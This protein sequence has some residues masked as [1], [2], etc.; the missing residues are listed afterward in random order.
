[1]PYKS[2]Q[3]VLDITQEQFTFAEPFITQLNIDRSDAI[4]Y[5]LGRRPKPI[6]CRSKHATLDVLDVV[7]EIRALF[8]EMLTS[9][10]D[11]VEFTPRRATQRVSGIAAQQYVND[12]FLCRNPGVA[13]FGD[14]VFDAAMYKL[15]VFNLEW[16]KRDNEAV[17]TFEELSEDDASTLVDSPDIVL[18][19]IDSKDTPE[20]KQYF[21]KYR[22]TSESPRVKLR[23]V[24]PDHFYMHE[25]AT[26]VFNPDF[27]TEKV[28]A[29]EGDLR[30]MGIPQAKIDQ[31]PYYFLND[32]DTISNLNT[33][34][35][36]YANIGTNQSGR[37]TRR[38]YNSFIVN[39]FE[40][41]NEMRLYQV[42][43]DENCLIDYKQ[44]HR[45]YYFWWTPL[46]VSHKTI[47]L[48]Y[49]DTTKGVQAHSTNLRRAILDHA[50]STTNRT[51]YANEALF[52]D[53]QRL[54]NERF[55]EVHNV[56]DIGQAIR[57][58]EVPQISPLTANVIDMLEGEKEKRS[59]FSATARGQNQD[60]I[61]KQNSRDMVNAM[62]NAGM[63]RPAQHF[64]VLLHQCLIPMYRAILDLGAMYDKDNPIYRYGEATVTYIPGN[65][66][67]NA[68]IF[69]VSSALTPQERAQQ[70]D[71]LIAMHTLFMDPQ[72]G[73]GDQ[74]MPKNREAL[75]QRVMK[76]KG[77]NDPHMLLTSTTDP[78]Y[79]EQQEQKREM[80]RQQQEQAEQLQ[81]AQ[82]QIQSVIA[83]AEQMKA[84]AAAEK[85]RN[86]YD[87]EQMKLMIDQ[88]KLILEESQ[89]DTN[90]A[91][92]RANLQLKREEL[93]AEIDKNRADAR[94][95]AS[96]QDVAR[97]Q[98]IANIRR[99][100][101]GRQSGGNGQ[102]APNKTTGKT[103][104]S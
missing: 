56:R 48:S 7:E 51:R 65:L 38:F 19:A 10:H 41:K 76:L 22:Q 66:N 82:L 21:G 70:G 100:D 92:A 54:Y 43:W 101:A 90:R 29:T 30:R 73:L 37:D 83:Q 53:P 71:N 72:S 86:D 3:D 63:R 64:K 45:H 24:R 94:V 60:V 104:S 18:L 23:L 103:G 99:A 97:I 102:S 28:G 39:D 11:V 57:E 89:L 14:F 78:A 33:T 35:L 32:Q 69:N 52:E 98:A 27:L 67:S 75:I 40:R 26:D 79:L 68:I 13:L 44:V 88:M 5:Y 46:R 81:Q 20:G 12:H 58:A 59:G 36:T 34:A 9:G 91:E 77:I 49:A 8:V 31:L 15:G 2:K 95:A 87:I 50:I 85:N 47:G 74:Y 93:D 42:R 84:Q 1:M 62:T 55:N 61:S 80:E 4:D 17:Y 96:H 16:E 25:M 6:P